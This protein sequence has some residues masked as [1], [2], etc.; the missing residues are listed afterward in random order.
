[1]NKQLK[2]LLF[3]ITAL[4]ALLISFFHGKRKSYDDISKSA[5]VTPKREKTIQPP[6]METG[7]FSSPYLNYRDL[8]TDSYLDS[9]I[10]G[11]MR[12]A[13]LDVMYGTPVSVTTY[14]GTSTATY[15]LASYS[16]ELRQEGGRV[17]FI[18]TF[19]NDVIKEWSPINQK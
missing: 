12:K 4:T 6:L 15:N 11:S 8:L 9:L 13:E 10:R 7:K 16:E 18:A 17:G 2:L 5:K 3:A 19:H 1:M 14:N